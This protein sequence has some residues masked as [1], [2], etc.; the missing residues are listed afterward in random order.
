MGYF[1]NGSYSC[2][3]DFFKIKNFRI[4]IYFLAS[5]D[6]FDCSKG[7]DAKELSF[8]CSQMFVPQSMMKDSFGQDIKIFP[9]G[10][11]IVIRI[12]TF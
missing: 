3:N 1:F 5:G 12:S 9:N 4:F 10:S 11:L 6:F 8:Q 2:H 7:I